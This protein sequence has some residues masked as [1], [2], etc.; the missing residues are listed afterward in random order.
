MEALAAR[1]PAGVPPP[2]GT[3]DASQ[4]MAA[5][6]GA[7]AD[8]VLHLE[9]QFARVALSSGCTVSVAIIVGRWL[10]VANVG[11]S[12]IVLDTGETIE[13][14]NID[15]RIEDNVREQERIIQVPLVAIGEQQ[16]HVRT[17]PCAHHRLGLP[18]RRQ[19]DSCRAWT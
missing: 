6:R 4:W 10:M 16:V 9:E 12:S 19:G 14:L 1:V 8:V 15:H 18:S 17:P 13:Q 2:L 3:R 5:F 7:V 11:D